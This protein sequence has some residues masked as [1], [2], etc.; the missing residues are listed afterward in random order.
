[1]GQ[2]LEAWEGYEIEIVGIG[3]VGERH[4]VASAHQSAKGRGSGVP[5]EMDLAYMT[6]LR[7]ETFVALH[8]Y[9]S[10]DDAVEAAERR[11]AG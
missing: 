3:P 10:R 5:V 4:V 1:M 8:L 6:E 11:E 2:W 9:P 7:G